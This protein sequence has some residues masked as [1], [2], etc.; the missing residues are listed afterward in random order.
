M[1]SRRGADLQHKDRRLKR[2]DGSRTYGP[3]DIQAPRGSLGQFTGRKVALYAGSKIARVNRATDIAMGCYPGSSRRGC[4]ISGNAK[5][6]PYSTCG[7]IL[8]VCVMVKSV[9]FSL[10]RGTRLARLLHNVRRDCRKQSCGE[11]MWAV[12]NSLTCIDTVQVPLSRTAK[13]S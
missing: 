13:I 7:M 5:H 4:N 9:I 1:K 12:C 10:L 8:S 6:I 3:D 11:T 2:G